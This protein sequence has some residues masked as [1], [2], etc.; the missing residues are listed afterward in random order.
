MGA[1]D[2]EAGRSG[3]DTGGA[4]TAWGDNCTILR[5]NTSTILEAHTG[6]T[7]RESVPNLIPS[8]Y[9]W[10]QVWMVLNNADE[11]DQVWQVYVQGPND[12]EPQLLQFNPDAPTSTLGFRRQAEDSLKFLVLSSNTN[13][14]PDVNTRDVWMVDDIY[15]DV[16]NANI[17]DPRVGEDDIIDPFGEAQTW[18]GFTAQSLSLIHI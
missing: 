13:K 12:T 14:S 9:T 10:Y 15:V 18:R 2:L 3:N 5:V 6:G 4:V 17:G 7:Y 8:T 1:T 11:G 16:G